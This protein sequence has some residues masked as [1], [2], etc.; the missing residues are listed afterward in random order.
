M[1]CF[2]KS[3]W[4]TILNSRNADFHWLV[5]DGADLMLVESF[6]YLLSFNQDAL[7]CDN[8]IADRP[9]VFLLNQ[10]GLLFHGMKKKYGI[11][12][13]YGLISKI[14]ETQYNFI[15]R[16]KI[17]FSAGPELEHAILDFTRTTV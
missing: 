15:Y 16:D 7:A 13:A 12:F 14:D 9:F 6:P 5:Q 10:N 17:K 4:R 11:F 3:I 1:L 2:F 8:C